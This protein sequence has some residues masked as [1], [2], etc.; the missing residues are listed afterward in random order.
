MSQLTK[1]LQYG[2]Y[3]SQRYGPNQLYTLKHFYHK[4]YSYHGLNSFI[5]LSG[6]LSA[7]Q[8][9]NEW[10][11]SKLPI[12]SLVSLVTL[13]SFSSYPLCRCRLCA[14]SPRWIYCFMFISVFS[15]LSLSLSL[16]LSVS[17]SFCSMKTCVLT[18]H[19]R[20]RNWRCYFNAQNILCISSI[21]YKYSNMHSRSSVF[22]VFM[23]VLVYL[24]ILFQQNL[25]IH[26]FI[27]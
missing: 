21:N 11:K 5:S 24:I 26:I 2:N 18:I 9:R 1:V 10:H 20:R 12:P 25:S 17:V 7:T 22:F 19:Q 4:R 13:L 15:C 23:T 8:S 27:Y 3:E 14:D 6:C 16:F